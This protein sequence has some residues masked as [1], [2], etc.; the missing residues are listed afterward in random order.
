MENLNAEQVKKALECCIT[1]SCISCPYDDVGVYSQ[2]VPTLL[3]NA[4]ALINS[5]EQRI[6]ELT[7][8]NERLKTDLEI[9]NMKRASIFEIADAFDRGRTAGVRKMQER[10]HERFH[11]RVAY[12]RSYVHDTID[13]IAKE[14][15][16]G[17]ING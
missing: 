7:E 6:K 8:E 1:D 5:Q 9:R 17:E 10:L 13:Q 12:T 14:M 3:E 15:L 4:L 16:E 2:C 11:D